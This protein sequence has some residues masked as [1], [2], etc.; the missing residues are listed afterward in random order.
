M[1]PAERKRTIVELV[2][3]RDGCSVAQLADELGFSKA[4]IRRDLRDLEAEGRIERSHG[5]AVPTSSVG[6]ERPYDKREV[7]RLSAKQAIADT[8]KAEVRDGQVVFFDSGTTTIEV[9]RA[10]PD[11]GYVA[12]T[13][14]PTLAT[15]LSERGVDVKLSGGTLRSRT[16]AL[17]GPTA[18]AFLDRTNFDLLFLGTNGIDAAAG[19]STPNEEEAEVKARMVERAG[20]VVLVADSSKFEERSFVTF[21][22]LDQVDVLVTDADPP[23]ALATALD[24]ADVLVESVSP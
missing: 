17:V 7:E 16:R 24:E 8:A 18:T 1:L 6:T 14:M 19:L 10:L 23:A 4:T 13:N 3:E 22:D 5:G 15:E 20:R 21:A 2:T 11:S 9:A 12:A